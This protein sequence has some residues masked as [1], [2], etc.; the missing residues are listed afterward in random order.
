MVFIDDLGALMQILA[1]AVAELDRGFQEVIVSAFLGQERGR[2]RILGLV[3]VY[4]C[5]RK[6]RRGSRVAARS[7]SSLQT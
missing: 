2:V 6:R 4:S 1:T 5:R 3:E 7:F